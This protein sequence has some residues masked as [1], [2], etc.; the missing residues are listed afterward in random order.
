MTTEEKVLERLEE[1]Y[2]YLANF[3]D[4]ELA[5]AVRE[6]IARLEKIHI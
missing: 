2:A 3:P 4:S 1:L 5:P 6:E